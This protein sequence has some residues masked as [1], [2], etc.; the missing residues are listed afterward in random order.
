M[1]MLSKPSFPH[2]ATRLSEGYHIFPAKPETVLNW[3]P[4]EFLEF[5]LQFQGM[6]HGFIIEE[7]SYAFMRAC[8]CSSFLISCITA[9]DIFI[10]T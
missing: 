1:F 9:S 2:V 8:A 7:N 6:K 10:K 4:L 5:T 3:E